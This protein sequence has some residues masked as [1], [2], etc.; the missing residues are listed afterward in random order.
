MLLRSTPPDDL[1]CRVPCMVRG[2]R[3]KLRSIAP[4]RAHCLLPP[5]V[6]YSHYVLGVASGFKNGGVFCCRLIKESCYAQGIWRL[7]QVVVLSER[8]VYP[9]PRFKSVSCCVFFGLALIFACH[10]PVF[11]LFFFS[12]AVAYSAEPCQQLACVRRSLDG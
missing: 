7:Y 9:S 10:F 12:G 1:Y 6:A 3:D 5:H 4:L 8:T 11:L 2:P